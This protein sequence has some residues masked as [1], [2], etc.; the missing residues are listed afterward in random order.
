MAPRSYKSFTEIVD[1]IGNS[2]VYGGIHFNYTCK[3]SAKQGSKI[4]KN[5]L[6][7]LKFKK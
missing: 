4:A 5:I 2:R 3:E 1:D 6:N 7:I